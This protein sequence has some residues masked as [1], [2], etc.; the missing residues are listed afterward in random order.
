MRDAAIA[1]VRSFNRTV[2]EGLGVLDDRFLGRGRPLGESRLLWEIGRG[3]VQIRDLR[4]RLG[5]DSG[6]VSRVLRSLSRHGLVRV[7]ADKPDR[8]VRR[9]SLTAKG[10]AERRVLDRRSDALAERLLQPLNE[11]QRAALVASMT[12]VER[13]L[14]ASM[15]RFAV[16]RP[17]SAAARWCLGQ[18]F[19]ELDARFDAGFDPERSISAHARELTPPAG[20]LLVARLRG[21]PIGCGALKLHGTAPA[22][23]KRMWIAPEARGLGLGARLLQEL[24]RQARDA[25]VRVLRLETNRALREAIALYRRSGYVEVDRFNDE[26]YAHHWFEKRLRGRARSGS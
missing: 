4:A 14:H 1:R 23:V 21:Q 20:L 13:L 12:S 19:A 11:R 22:E 5:L 24:E 25:G 10:I 8:R 16:E 17:A 9:A 18:Y 26:P 3:G 2:T 6:Y 7:R 15:V